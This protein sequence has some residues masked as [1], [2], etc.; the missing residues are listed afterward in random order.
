MTCTCQVSLHHIASAKKKF[1]FIPIKM[2]DEMMKN[3]IRGAHLHQIYFDE[4]VPP[5]D[6]EKVILT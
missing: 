1:A 3:M 2:H 5:D 4:C 6:R